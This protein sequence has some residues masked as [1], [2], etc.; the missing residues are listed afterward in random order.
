MVRLI[1]SLISVFAVLNGLVAKVIEDLSVIAVWFLL[2]VVV[3]WFLSFCY[4][5]WETE[6]K[7]GR[8]HV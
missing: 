8:A 3:V 6:I 5:D 4:R 2:L 7:I 1:A